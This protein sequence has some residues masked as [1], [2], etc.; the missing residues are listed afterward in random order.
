MVKLSQS[1]DVNKLKFVDIYTVKEKPFCYSWKIYYNKQQNLKN[2]NICRIIHDFVK[3][4]LSL[5]I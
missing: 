4:S 3:H 2:K 5:E 1:Q